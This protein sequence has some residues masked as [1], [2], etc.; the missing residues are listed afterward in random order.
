MDAIQTLRLQNML[1]PKSRVFEVDRVA[2]EHSTVIR[3]IL[4][5]F[6]ESYLAGTSIPIFL[7]VSDKALAK[8]LQW[9]THWKDLPKAA[10]VVIDYSHRKTETAKEKKAKGA[11]ENDETDAS[12]LH[13]PWNK[14]TKKKVKKTDEEDETDASVLH[15]PWNKIFFRGVNATILYEILVIANYLD[16]KPLCDLCCELVAVL[17]R[18]KPIEEVCEI[19]CIEMEYAN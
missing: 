7:D 2:A 10:D 14:M 4:A 1:N 6:D 3:T 9:A 19:L 12:V 15:N 16:I 8:V 11:S 5:E 18:G 13:N 17:I